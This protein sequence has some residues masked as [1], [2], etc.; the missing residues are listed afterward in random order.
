[1]KLE[2]EQI[3]SLKKEIGEKRFNEITKPKINYKEG[4]VY[5][6]KGSTHV[7]KLHAIENRFAWIS[8]NT[9]N[10]LANGSFNTAE[11]AIKTYPDC[12][13][14]DSIKHAVEKGFFK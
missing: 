12:E 14:F 9:S 3:K 11:F 10:C 4:K 7:Y 1:M 6:F 2:E 8:L 13:E 5:L